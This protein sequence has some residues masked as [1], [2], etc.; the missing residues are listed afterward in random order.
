MRAVVP[1]PTI[2]PQPLTLPVSGLTASLALE[3]VGEI[4]QNEV[5]L[6]TAGQHMHTGSVLSLML[7]VLSSLYGRIHGYNHG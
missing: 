4:K 6:V 5:V 7:P 1:L 3:Y 2:S